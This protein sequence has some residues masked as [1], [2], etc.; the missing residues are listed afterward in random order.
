MWLGT[1]TDHVKGW[2]DRS[3]GDGNVLFV[4]FEDMTRDLPAMICRV[5]A[6]LGMAPLYPLAQ[7]YPDVAAA[8]DGS[9]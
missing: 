7:T 6:F 3:R 4:H 8:R 5:A 2:W 1:W 9:A